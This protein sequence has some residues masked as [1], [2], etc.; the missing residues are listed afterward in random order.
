MA[1]TVIITDDVTGQPGAKPRTLVIDS[2][3]YEVDL[4]TASLAELK[5][6][7]KPFLKNA[8]VVKN[9]R[10]EKARPAG[11]KKAAAPRGRKSRAKAA[12][13]LSA[14]ARAWAL[15][16]GVAVPKRGRVP[17]SVIDAYRAAK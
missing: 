13:N 7:I 16:N 3:E 1:R 5:N 11:A 2:V 14:E 8:R 10:A 6:A 15:E 9:G 17:A 12:P 4:T